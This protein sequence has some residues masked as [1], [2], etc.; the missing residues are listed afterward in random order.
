MLKQIKTFIKDE[1]GASA[2]EYALVAALIAIAIITAARTLGTSV[3]GTFNTIS[4]NLA[5]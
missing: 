4:T 2:I 1:N 5:N 3:S